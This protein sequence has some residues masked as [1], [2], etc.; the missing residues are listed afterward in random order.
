VK[1]QPKTKVTLSIPLLDLSTVKL[2]LL[3]EK[4]NK[5]LESL[6]YKLV[7]SYVEVETKDFSIFIIS[8]ETLAP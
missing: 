1:I 3:Q 5:K 4:S 6:K 7:G 2:N 8:S